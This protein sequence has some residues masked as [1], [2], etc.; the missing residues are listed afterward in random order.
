M[1][2]LLLV[3][4]TMHSDR[5]RGV[6][7]G[8]PVYGT[9]VV[10]LLDDQFAQIL[11]SGVGKGMVMGMIFHKRREW[12]GDV[13]QG[14]ESQ[15]ESGEVEGVCLH[16]VGSEL[17]DDLKAGERSATKQFLRD[18]RARDLAS[19]EYDYCDIIY[20]LVVDR[21]G[22]VWA[23]RGI[24][25]IGG[26]NGNWDANRGFVSICV[27]LGPGLT[28]TAAQERGVGHAIK[29]VRKK[30]PRAQKVVGHSMFVP[31]DCPGDELRH[32]IRSGV[33]G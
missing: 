8:K 5:G 23:G 14:C 21:V 9:R 32:K 26:A 22:E 19:S 11:K 13:G 24:R 18:T 10:S 27:I 17:G 16:W 12:N 6:A 30:Y 4:R 2:S 25:Y 31:T 7:G 3:L 33:W 29:K 28:M 1:F 20:N 15:F